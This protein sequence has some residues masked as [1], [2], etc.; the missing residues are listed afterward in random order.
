MVSSLSFLSRAH[1]ELA[2]CGVT[3]YAVV[4]LPILWLT[5]QLGSSESPD[6]SNAEIV[7]QLIRLN[8]SKCYFLPRAREFSS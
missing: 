5:Y 1:L 2:S 6:I 3:A 7:C 8:Y 4:L